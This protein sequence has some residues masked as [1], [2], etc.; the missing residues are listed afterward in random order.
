MQD[1]SFVSVL[2]PPQLS[3]VLISTV[4]VCWVQSVF[5]VQAG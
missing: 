5:V 2:V 3:L 1:P 4:L